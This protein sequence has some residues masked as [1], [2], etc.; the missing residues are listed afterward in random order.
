MAGATR[1]L[2]NDFSSP[3]FVAHVQLKFLKLAR[4]YFN[5]SVKDEF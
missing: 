5:E 4:S 2:R 1:D 3:I